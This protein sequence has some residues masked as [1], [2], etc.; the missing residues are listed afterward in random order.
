VQGARKLEAGWLL[1]GMRNGEQNYGMMPRRSISRRD[2]TVC[3]HVL[4]RAAR[5]H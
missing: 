4:P 3:I 2:T 1:C 5:I